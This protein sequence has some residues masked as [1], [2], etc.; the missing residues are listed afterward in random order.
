[1]RRILQRLCCVQIHKD[2]IS[3]IT[4]TT[5][6]LTSGMKIRST[7]SGNYELAVQKFNRLTT[8]EKE[9]T[10]INDEKYKEENSNRLSFQK[11]DPHRV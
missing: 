6:T 11:F 5:S 2:K 4:W 3:S 9:S 8:T 1:M 7:T 10:P